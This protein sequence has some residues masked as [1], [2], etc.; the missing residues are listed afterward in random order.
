MTVA[1]PPPTTVPVDSDWLVSAD[2]LAVHVTCR[3]DVAIVGL[4]GDV[5]DLTAPALVEGLDL[6]LAVRPSPLVVDASAMSFCCVRGFAALLDG[7][8]RAARTGAS[9]AVAGLSPLQVRL[10]RT[11]WPHRD[12]TPFGHSSLSDALSHGPPAPDPAVEADR[13]ELAH[14]RRAMRTRA[15]IEQAKGVMMARRSCSPDE[16][17]RLLAEASQRTNRKLHLVA[18]AVV[19]AVQRPDGST[20]SAVPDGVP[21]AAADTAR[22]PARPGVR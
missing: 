10:I 11:G 21:V 13:T 5:D 7:T 19:G 1:P 4:R 22:P 3:G 8:G 14:L 17:F 16:A 2:G 20:G 18:A 12:P 6:A 15:T 9:V